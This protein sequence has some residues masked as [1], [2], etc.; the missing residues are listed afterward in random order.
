MFS[1]MKST[2]GHTCGQIFVN[3][4]GFYHFTPMNKESEA[5]NALVEFIQHVGI[6]SKIHTDGSKLQSKGNWAKLIKSYHIKHSFTEP[7]TPW[8]NRAEGA[9]KELK[10]H[11]ARLMRVTNSPK[12]LW[13]YCCLLVTRLR[14]MTPNNYYLAKGQTPHEIVTGD[15]PDISEYCAFTWYEPVW[16]LDVA[17][18]PQEKKKLGI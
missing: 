10:R 2:N 13:G 7:H 9:I 1:S 5:S 4:I 15:T 12:R 11:T 18:H 3:N 16:Y 6:P 17:S 14:N 8:Q